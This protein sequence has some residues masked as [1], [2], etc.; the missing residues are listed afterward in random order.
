MEIVPVANGTAL[1]MINSAHAYSQ[2][3]TQ[4]AEGEAERFTA[5]V[6]EF[7]KAQEITKKRMYLEAMNDI[8]SSAGIQK[9]I[10]SKDVKGSVLPLLNLEQMSPQMGSKPARSSG[11]AKAG[12]A[13]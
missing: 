7:N 2:R 5:M 10:L 9:T 3:I 1:G 8:L 6:N 11:N 12:G 4:S 13:E